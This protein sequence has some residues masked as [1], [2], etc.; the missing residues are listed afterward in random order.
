[1]NFGYAPNYFNSIKHE[2]VKAIPARMIKV[3]NRAAR[4]F[5]IRT[6]SLI[7]IRRQFIGE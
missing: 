7:N 6:N 1:M 2:M 5:N 3:L 4:L